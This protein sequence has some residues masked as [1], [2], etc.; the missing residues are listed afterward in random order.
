LLD[1]GKELLDKLDE[2][3]DELGFELDDELDTD[4]LEE[5]VSTQQQG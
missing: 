2:L 3:T 1:D 4:E 5:L